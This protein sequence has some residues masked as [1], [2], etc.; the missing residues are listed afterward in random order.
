MA[1][2]WLQKGKSADKKSGD[3]IWKYPEND[4][5]LESIF[6]PGG[7]VQC[8]YKHS[9]TCGICL[10]AI[11]EVERILDPLQAEVDFHYI[12]VKKDRPLSQKVAAITG[13]QHESP[14]ILIINDGEVFWHTSHGRIKEKKLLEVFEELLNNRPA[15]T[16]DG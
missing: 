11:K 4:Q 3:N 16:T 1:F 13:V 12:D 7:K 9:T 6:Q 5:D 15:E 8:V 14:Q 10:F 2:K